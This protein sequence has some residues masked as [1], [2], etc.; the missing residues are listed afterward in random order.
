[1]L[2]CSDIETVNAPLKTEPTIIAEGSIEHE[3][4]FIL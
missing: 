4:F 1:M 2:S 3:Q